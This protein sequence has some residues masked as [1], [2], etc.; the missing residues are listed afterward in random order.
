M[1]AK[2][3][4]AVTIGRAGVD[5]YGDQIGARLED[6]GS[7]SK[8]I[9]GSPTN[10]AIG[11][12]RLGAKTALISR[13]GDDAMG[14]FIKEELLREGVEVSHVTTDKSAMTALVLLGI[15]DE[16]RFPLIFYREN[17]ADMNISRSDIDE[18]LIAR[19]QTVVTSGTHFS[20]PQTKA[21]SLYALELARKHGASAWI[22]LDY[23]P[24]LWGLGSKGDGETRFIADDGV[25]AHLQSILGAL[26]VIVGTE[27]EIHI[28]GGISDTIGALKALRARTEATFIVKL[29]A[30]GCAV[31]EDAIPDSIEDAL[32][33]RGAEVEVFNVL[34][35]GDAFMGGLITG[36]TEGLGW[37][38]AARMA[39]LCGAFAVSRHACAPSYP[40]RIELEAF[41]SEGSSHYRLREDRK[42]AQ[43]HWS[44][45]RHESWPEVLIFAFDHRAQFETRTS[46]ARA[47][48]KFKTLCSEVAIE[49][50]RE[51]PNRGIGA[52]CDRRYGL[53]AL[54]HLTDQGLWLGSPVE[55]PGS[56]PLRFEGGA[57]ISDYLKEIPNTHV[58]KCLSFIHPKDEAA[59]QEAQHR[60]LLALSEACRTWGH[61]LLLE[62]IPPDGME[63]EA[64]TTSDTMQQVYDLGIAPD[65]WKLPAPK[66]A[67]AE[68]A[69]QSISDVVSRYDAQCRGV[70]LLGRSAPISEVKSSLAQARAIP[71]CKGFAVGRTIF[72]GAA[73]AWFQNQIDDAAAKRMMKEVFSELIETW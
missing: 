11:A 58:I 39:N 37:E 9:G 10:T 2:T 6:M 50:A 57:N 41:M 52:L 32:C 49:A 69:W 66:E 35:A 3:L 67:H 47:I 70:L 43:L 18:G 22:D 55:W 36:W 65:W 46:D 71:I 56:R 28:A 42:L 63:I 19:A 40:S 13:V 34:G 4:N 62:L 5:L 73:S 30:L 20:T 12:A 38:K 48:Q 27:E 29:G 54:H 61:E 7:F 68:R 16:T 44:T 51:H 60:N 53:E 45:T 15:R 31:F 8:Y 64:E 1:G 17:C 26:D 24:V 25:T 21:A 33:V 72:E 14:R 23:R 59:L